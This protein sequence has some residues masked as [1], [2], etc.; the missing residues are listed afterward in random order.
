MKK[1]TQL[2]EFTL[3]TTYLFDGIHIVQIVENLESSYC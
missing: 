2:T 3:V 1:S